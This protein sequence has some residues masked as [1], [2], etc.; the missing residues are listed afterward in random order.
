MLRVSL[1][2]AALL[3]AGCASPKLPEGYRS[4]N[5]P[6]T[7]NC[8]A[9]PQAPAPVSCRNLFEDTIHRPTDSSGLQ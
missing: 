8:T 2:V 7:V 3:M 4:K 1:L 6:G 9:Y 5:L